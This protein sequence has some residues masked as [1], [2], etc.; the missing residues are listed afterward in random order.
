MARWTV[1]SMPRSCGA[2]G[3]EI[4]AGDPVAL[5][6]AKNLVRCAFCAGVDLDHAQVDEARQRL[7]A[8]LAAVS[9]VTQFE[10]YRHRRTRAVAPASAI[11]TSLFDAKAVRAGNDD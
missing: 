10:L 1:G 9:P 5:L 4:P 7:A 11:D 6:T 2:C 8:E 3:G